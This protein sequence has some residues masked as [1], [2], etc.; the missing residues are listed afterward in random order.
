[1]VF[2]PNKIMNEPNYAPPTT[3]KDRSNQV[4]NMRKFSLAARSR[5]VDNNILIYVSI[6]A[7]PGFF[8]HTQ[9]DIQCFSA[10]STFFGFLLYKFGTKWT[11]FLGFWCFSHNVLLLKWG[12]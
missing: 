2:I 11:F 1:M 7:S 9:D 8:C 10:M 12:K 6:L 5:C 3:C 4:S